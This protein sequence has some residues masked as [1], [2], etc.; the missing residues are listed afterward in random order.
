MLKKQYSKD[1][2]ACKVTFTLPKEAAADA[3]EVKVLGDFNNWSWENGAL[4]VAS[5]VEYAATLE[6]P[7]G[8][9][10]AF[11][12]LIDNDTWENDWQADSYET[13]KYGVYNSVLALDSA[14][15]EAPVVPKA[16]GATKTATKASDKAAP[17]K[18]D[19]T[20]AAKPAAAKATAPKAKAT[21]A[22]D[23]TKIE[24]VGPKIA[25]LLNAAGIAT[26]ADLAK[27]KTA[28][29]QS[30]LEGA[31]P[32]YKM[33]DPATWAEQ[34]KLATKGEW[35]KLDSLQEELKGG[36]RK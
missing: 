11:R 25:E 1:K 21:V 20:K 31:G 14:E 27:A 16:K 8:K 2:S 13:N 32:R 5:K 9:S 19:S 6:L 24:G 28:A 26:F 22:D 17:A 23:L 4:M 30:V 12:Y 35:S 18:K 3:K 33:H 29:L 15:A 10:Y 34:A 7:T 36:K